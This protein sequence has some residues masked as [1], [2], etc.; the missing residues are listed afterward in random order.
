MMPGEMFT[1]KSARR[2][3]ATRRDEIHAYTNQA[4]M[5]EYLHVRS[6]YDP[7]SGPEQAAHFQQ[8]V[9]KAGNEDAAQECKQH[10]G[11]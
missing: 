8:N 4:Y 10:G 11:C 7:T 9:L 3:L 5:E 6:I 2:A 1:G